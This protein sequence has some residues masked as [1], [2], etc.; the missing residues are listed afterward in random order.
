MG[1]C[2]AI[3]MTVWWQVQAAGISAVPLT[4]WQLS[5]E[6]PPVLALL[7]TGGISLVGVAVCSHRV[8]LTL[9][10]GVRSIFIKEP[11]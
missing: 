5:D 6:G 7:P 10:F 11:M 3:T 1:I 8:S 2:L 9:H 4:S